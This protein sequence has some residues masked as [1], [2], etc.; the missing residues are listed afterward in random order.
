[1]R[2]F[3]VA[4]LEAP[5]IE[6]VCFGCYLCPVCPAGKKWFK[7]IDPRYDTA[8][9][10]SLPTQRLVVD[11]VVRSRMSVEGAAEFARRVFHLTTLDPSTVLRWLRKAGDSIDFRG[12]QRAAIEGFSGQLAVDEVYDGDDAILI[13]TDPLNDV[14]LDWRHVDGTPCTE[15]VRAFFE[16]LRAQGLR[17]ELVVTDG[18]PLYPSVIAEVWPKA[19]HQRCVFHFIKQANEDLAKAFWAAYNALPKPKKRGPGRP[20]KRGRPRADK[21]KRRRR[22]R[23]RQTRYLVLK[24][25]DRLTKEQRIR[26]K[27]AIRICPALGVIRRFVEALH[28][29]FGPSTDTPELA[30]QRRQAILGD[31]AFVDCEGLAKVMKRLADDDLFERLTRHLDFENAEKTSNHVE[32][33]NREFRRRQ[34]THYR[35]RSLESLCALLD[36]LATRRPQPEP[37]RR[38]RLR[39]RRP[40]DPQQQQEVLAA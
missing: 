23:V 22:R 25:E 7:V 30:E 12:W 20:K 35:I 36:L 39:R 33:E 29:L 37:D 18:S 11:L 2:P 5:R 9:H 38:R 3:K 40:T 6:E 19:G 21:S 24:R 15:D 8:R 26:L 34:K 27:R 32:R 1:M 13:A 17:P 16:E 14:Q 28:E 4:D 10:Y 31:A